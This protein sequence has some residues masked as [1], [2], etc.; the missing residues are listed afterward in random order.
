MSGPRVAVAGVVRRRQGIGEHLAR[1]VVRHGGSVPAFLGSRPG[2]LE[3][4]RAVLARHGI[5]SRGFT[6]LSELLA[7]CPVDALVIASPARTHLPLLRAA[8]DAGLHVLC[9]KPL[10]ADVADAPG[11]AGTLTE[12]FAA[13][14]LLLWENVQWPFTL[15]AYRALHPAGTDAPLRHFAMRLSPMEGGA[16]HMLR[17]CV[18]H[19]LSVLQAL[20]PPSAAGV[21]G[22]MFSTRDPAADRIEVSF[23]YPGGASGVAVRVT[24]AAV[25][26]QPR[27][28][29][30][31]LNGLT[32]ERRVRL[33]EYALTFEHGGRAVDVP[34]PTDA[35][36][37][38]FVASLRGAPVPALPL[39]G[40][41]VSWRAR[42]LEE[43]VTGFERVRARS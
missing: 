4:G 35:L 38:A 40:P 5:A 33:P 12:E 15:G 11:V 42:A 7:T 30:Y 26:E 39:S 18:S 20:A 8:R 31:A 24:L 3:D 32:A 10:V 17:E 22:L 25:R 1:F 16:V 2:S 37:A 6:D 9:E 13:R 36:V 14:G 43:I 21:Q 27:P 29:S 34:D 19:P 23:R 41:A 28:A